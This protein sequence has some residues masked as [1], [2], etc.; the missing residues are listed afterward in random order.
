MKNVFKLFVVACSALLTLAGCE[1]DDDFTPEITAEDLTVE[2][3]PS[4][5]GTR[6]LTFSSNV[7]WSLEGAEASGWCAVSPASGL[8]AATIVVTI[9]AR[10]NTSAD[11]RSVTLTLK[12]EGLERTFP[13]TVS[14]RKTIVMN[15]E[16]TL[17]EDV[18]CEGQ[19]FDVALET[20][21]SAEEYSVEV[22]DESAS[23]LSAVRTKALESHAVAV[24]VGA[25]DLKVSRTGEVRIVWSDEDGRKY[26]QEIT[27]VQ[28]GIDN[29][30]PD[31]KVITVQK[32][33]LGH[34]DLVF[35]GDGFIA[36]QMDADEGRYIKAMRDAIE[37][38]FDVEPY[39]TYR[40]YFNV[41]IVSA[42]SPEEGASDLQTRRRTRFSVKFEG[43]QGETSMTC[44]NNTVFSYATK[45]PI[46]D[47]AKTL[48][49]LISNSPRYGG[50]TISWS[51]GQSIAICPMIE[52][53]PPYDYKSVVQ[54]EAGGH[55][56]GKLCDEYIYYD[57]EIP[58][59]VVSTLQQWTS[60]G[61]N[62]NIDF[63]N[64]PEKIKWRHF[65]ALDGYS[66]IV[67]AFEGGYMFS[68]GIW[69]P[70]TNSCMNNN[71]PYYNAPSRQKIVERIMELSGKE[72][73]F[74][75]FLAEDEKVLSTV[76]SI[77]APAFAPLKEM[78]HFA[79]PVLIEGS[80]FDA[81]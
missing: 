77:K 49:I 35:M 41:Y 3:I 27:V 5:G 4:Y 22:A 62:A 6:L 69:R 81:K 25:S 42:V 37:F 48:I 10:P 70:E 21:L 40:D 71:V 36:D 14:Q 8:P 72:F 63:T 24:T 65:Y 64:D 11:D 31:G 15:V 50:T 9:T 45:A 33:T 54:H 1:K 52:G 56:F 51:P 20:N 18:P 53:E 43:Q 34:A 26:S 38:F 46:D 75:A 76:N 59:N 17:F 28:Q 66:R 29:S 23:W 55:G 73:D 57:Q 30:L 58:K 13:V 68:K 67:N 74:D 61:H 19:T 7:P 44:D 39:K 2:A 32:G 60:F 47:L 16:K 80:P 12:G 79:A 78:P